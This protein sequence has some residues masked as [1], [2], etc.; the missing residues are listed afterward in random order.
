MGSIYSRETIEQLNFGEGK[1]LYG[2]TPLVM[3]KS[4]LQSGV[5]YLGGYPGSPTAGI[6]D[7]IS[8]AYEPVLKNRGIYFDSSGNEAAAAALLS[9]SITYPLSVRSSCRCR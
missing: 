6:I 2:D 5:S 7:A 9:A 3:L 8:D 4:F 1:I